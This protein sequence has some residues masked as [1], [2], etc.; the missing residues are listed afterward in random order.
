MLTSCLSHTVVAYLGGINYMIFRNAE[1][2]KNFTFLEEH[3]FVKEDEKS[4]GKFS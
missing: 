2:F 1:F 3:I 4:F